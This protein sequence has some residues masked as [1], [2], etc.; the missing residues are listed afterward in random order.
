MTFP[1]VSQCMYK[2]H[3]H[4]MLDIWEK[5]MDCYINGKYSWTDIVN[6]F[7][8]TEGIEEVH[9]QLSHLYIYTGRAAFCCVCIHL[10][11]AGRQL[12]KVDTDTEPAQKQLHVKI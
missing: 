12:I 4:E 10:G 5:C 1:R 6:F 9:K 8:H 3:S 7:F 11:A 2:L